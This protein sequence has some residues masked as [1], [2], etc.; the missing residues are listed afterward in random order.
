[1]VVSSNYRYKLY[2]TGRYVSET[3]TVYY[4]DK[5]IPIGAQV[6]RYN[7]AIIA[8]WRTKKAVKTALMVT[9]GVNE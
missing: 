4:S 1:M 9:T 7:F 8:E 3:G 6:T 5:R 2:V